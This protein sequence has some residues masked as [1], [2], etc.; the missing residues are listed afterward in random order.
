MEI[1][2]CYDEYKSSFFDGEKWLPSDPENQDEVKIAYER[3][4]NFI[5]R[6]FVLLTR[7]IISGEYIQAPNINDILSEFI[8]DVSPLEF[9]VNAGGNLT[10]LKNRLD[11]LNKSL[12]NALR[13]YQLFISVSKKKFT[14]TPASDQYGLF[15]IINNVE[16]NTL[17]LFVDISIALCK[18]DYYLPVSKKEFQNLLS[19]RNKIK[20]LIGS[21][22]STAELRSIYSLL[23]FKCHFIIKRIKKTRFDNQINFTSEIVNPAV[24]DIGDYESFIY[25]E[26]ETKEELLENIKSS[27]P[28]VK[29]FV[30]LM[31]SYKKSFNKKNDIVLMDYV[32]Q[33][34]LEIYDEYRNPIF[35]DDDEFKTQYDQFSLDTILNFLHN[36]RFSSFTQECEPTLKDIKNELRKIEDVQSITSVKNFHPYEKA[37]EVLILC[38]KKHIQKNN[39]DEKLLNDKL[40]ELERLLKSFENTL[41][42]SE[43]HKFFPFQ[44][45]FNESLV[46]SD[47]YKLNLFI[48]SA[49][50]KNIDYDSLKEELNLFKKEYDKLI[51]LKDLSKERREIE[52]I[53]EN[54]KNTDKKA[55][56]VIA[57]FIAAITFLF[58]TVNIF[59]NNSDLNLFQLIS[60]TVGLGILLL[61]F[62]SLYLVFSPLLTQTEWKNYFKTGRFV[63]GTIWIFLYV[64]IVLLLYVNTEELLVK[65]NG[66]SKDI[67]K[68]ILN[69]KDTIPQEKVIQTKNFK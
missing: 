8:R 63:F 31:R 13:Y 64:V 65:S 42:W 67:K 58:G 40:E 57:V 45:P 10:K 27:T 61:L 30:F 34:F 51:L 32:I 6:S 53:K 66:Q 28:K 9:S 56:D 54:I 15:N 22:N 68:E 20:E 11:D 18:Y 16:N 12:Y 25:K 4:I 41:K 46:Y 23:L 17:S 50:A 44:L 38:V 37:I 21:S 33:R 7:S 48:P 36:C 39:Y 24:L 60:N 26:L 3:I 35:R 62:T 59:A 55:T 43:F 19:I 49:F 2:T 29:S 1:K 14:T 47:E 5:D 69:K 52:K